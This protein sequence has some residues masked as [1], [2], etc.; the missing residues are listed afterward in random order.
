[1]SIEEGADAYLRFY[2]TM[3]PD[4]LDELDALVTPYVRFTDPF[5]DVRGP[6]AMRH[7]F[8]D[9]FKKVQ[10]PRFYVTYK[11]YD[12]NVLLVRWRFSGHVEAFGKDPWVVE[13]V[14]EIHIDADGRISAHIDH[15]DA[16]AQLYERLPLVGPLFRFIRRRA[17][18]R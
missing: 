3:S 16:A 1:M 4:T 13:G 6:E 11:A 8:M 18:S 12:G 9:M 5:N 2:E 15:W 17:G 7:I 10:G 14:S